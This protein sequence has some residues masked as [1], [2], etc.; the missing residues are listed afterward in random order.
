M[1][2]WWN[3][4]THH[5][6]GVAAQAMRVQ[7]PPS[8]PRLSSVP[9]RVQTHLRRNHRYGSPPVGPAAQH[10]VRPSRSSMPRATALLPSAGGAGVP[11]PGGLGV[12][13][14]KRAS[15]ASRA[16]LGPRAAGVKEVVCRSMVFLATN[17]PHWL[18]TPFLGMRSGI[19]WVHSRRAEVSKNTH[20]RQ[21]WRS[22]PH[23]GHWVSSPISCERGRP[24]H[25]AADHLLK[26]GH[27]LGAKLGGASGPGRLSDPGPRLPFV[28][29]ITGLAVFSRHQVL[30]V[31]GRPGRVPGCRLTCSA[32]PGMGNH[33]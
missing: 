24:A 6:E 9:S 25:G 32:A 19:F 16:V 26:A 2:K 29:L 1:R 23:L 30:A 14:L 27:R 4:Q 18:R 10:A 31:A 17:R 13:F 28:V 11:A 8:A 5:L 22:A 20:C 33:C 15:K 12:Q 3:W 21:V 7:V